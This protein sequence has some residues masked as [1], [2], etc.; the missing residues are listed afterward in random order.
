MY[1]PCLCGDPECPACGPYYGHTPRTR[2]PLGSLSAEEIDILNEQ[3]AAD[4]EAEL[5]Y[6]R[7]LDD[8]NTYAEIAAADADAEAAYEDLDEAEA[9]D[10][11]IF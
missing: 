8:A 10:T 3:A 5:T 11:D 4:E 1:E 9:M 6:R 7:M 2:Y